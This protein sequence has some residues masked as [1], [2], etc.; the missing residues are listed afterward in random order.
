LEPHL[1]ACI[2]SMG[3]EAADNCLSLEYAAAELS[4]SDVQALAGSGRLLADSRPVSQSVSCSIASGDSA[5]PVSNAA[6]LFGSLFEG[7]CSGIGSQIAV[8][9]SHDAALNAA[10][11]ES[12]SAQSRASTVAKAAFREA[13]QEVYSYAHRMGMGGRIETSGLVYCLDTSEFCAVKVGPYAAYLWR[14]GEA[15][16]LFED[17]RPTAT[18]EAGAIRRFIGANAQVLADVCTITLRDGDT[19]VICSV[20]PSRSLQAAVSQTFSHPVPVTSAAASLL[21]DCVW[22][23]SRV[24]SHSE[25]DRNLRVWVLRLGRPIIALISAVKE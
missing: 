5:P 19:L 18:E 16:Q 15:A 4:L 6:L 8:K 1:G 24:S 12:A 20:P 2:L 10:L 13:N 22:H 14:A 25:L 23:G 9:M 21:R 11:T 17:K 3:S 7:S